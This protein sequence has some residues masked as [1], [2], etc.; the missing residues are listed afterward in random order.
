MKADAVSR[1]NFDQ[2]GWSSEEGTNAADFCEAVE[3]L[4]RLAGQFSCLSCARW[5]LSA[6]I[7]TIE[8][9]VEYLTPG[10]SGLATNDIG[11]EIKVS[12]R[13]PAIRPCPSLRLRTLT[14][15][16]LLDIY[17]RFEHG[18]QSRKSQLSSRLFRW[19]VVNEEKSQPKLSIGYYCMTICSRTA[20]A[21][22]GLTVRARKLTNRQFLVELGYSTLD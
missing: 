2:V 10:L 15:V 21:P 8:R 9:I 12:L 16:F 1:Q 5:E 22:C 19:S 6:N 18:R 7:L 4:I 3:G 20:L 14:R 11:M 17:R 13:I